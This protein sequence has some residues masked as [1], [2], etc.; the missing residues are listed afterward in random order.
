MIAS[1]IQEGGKSS[2]VTATNRLKTLK[3]WRRSG[4]VQNVTTDSI[5]GQPGSPHA[6]SATNTVVSGVNP[7]R[8]R[9]QSATRVAADACSGVRF[10][11]LIVM[12]RR[13][14]GRSARKVN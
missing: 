14:Y 2:S 10:D 4:A 11:R 8:R 12:L 5:G 7:N 13:R 9:V 6:T 1:F 3:L